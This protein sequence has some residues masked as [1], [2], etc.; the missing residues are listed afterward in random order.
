M[1]ELLILNGENLKDDSVT[2]LMFGGIHHTNQGV[3]V[4]G[5]EYDDV[6]VD[7]GEDTPKEWDG[8]LQNLQREERDNG[9]SRQGKEEL[10]SLLRLYR[11]IFRVR[12]G[13]DEAEDVEPMRI[14]LK[15]NAQPVLCKP[16]RYHPEQ[17]K[18]LNNYADQLLRAGFVKLNSNAT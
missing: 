13:T 14:V 8:A 2:R 6:R 3:D 9:L 18:F 16:R 15:P 10:R 7:L 1:E 12:L 5:A 11:D 4:D 17:R